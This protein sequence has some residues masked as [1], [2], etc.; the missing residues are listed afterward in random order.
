MKGNGNQPTFQ[1]HLD[2][3]AALLLETRPGFF[4]P[5]REVNAYIMRCTGVGIRQSVNRYL[6]AWEDLGLIEWHKG[7]KGDPGGITIL[8]TPEGLA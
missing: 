5:R 7:K 1:T 6:E 8:A 3:H 4:L 2:L